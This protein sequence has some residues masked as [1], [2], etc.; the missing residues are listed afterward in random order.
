MYT[1]VEYLD[2]NYEFLIKNMIFCIFLN[3]KAFHE[4]VGNDP[5]FLSCFHCFVTI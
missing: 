3:S 2:T 5:D 1:F 4:N